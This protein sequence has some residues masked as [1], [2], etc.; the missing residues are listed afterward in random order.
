MFAGT[1][2]IAGPT[3]EVAAIN[4]ALGAKSMI[5]AQCE[6]LVKQY[7]PQIIDAVETMPTD[8][9]C[10]H[11]QLCAAH[12]KL[13]SSSA[14]VARSLLSSDGQKGTPRKILPGATWN[15]QDTQAAAGDGV[16]CEFCRLAVQYVKMALANNQTIDEIAAAVGGLCNAMSFGGPDVIDC[17]SLDKLPVINFGVGGRN[18]PL[19]PRD[20]VLRIDQGGESQCVSGFMGLDVPAGPLWI[21]GDICIGAYH[22][23]FDVD[24]AQVGFADAASVSR[25][26]K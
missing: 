4:K 26:N 12:A 18:F 9:V 5:A 20:Y 16:G 23:V 17:E 1:S 8:E 24:N 3:E 21:L 7:L 19:H 14:A 22:T 15:Q 10:D 13:R 11:L 25:G 2:L 6:A